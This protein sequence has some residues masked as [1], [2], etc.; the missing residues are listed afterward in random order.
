MNNH[1][2]IGESSFVCI[3]DAQTPLTMNSFIRIQSLIC[4]KRW[5]FVSFDGGLR[6]EGNEVE[7]ID[8]RSL[9][10]LFFLRT[11]NQSTSLF[12]IFIGFIGPSI[13]TRCVIHHSAQSISLHRN[14]LKTMNNDH[15]NRAELETH[16]SPYVRTH[17]TIHLPINYSFSI[18]NFIL[19]SR[20]HT[21]T[22]TRKFHVSMTV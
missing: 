3:I 22:R 13:S 2:L 17:F 19:T 6:D 15:R 4:R 8:F 11:V 16:R 20:R 14:P 7:D 18:R 1:K 9:K 5:I 12:C 21:H 10:V